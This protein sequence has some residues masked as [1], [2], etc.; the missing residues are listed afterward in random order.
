[1]NLV[2]LKV[3]RISYSQSQNGAYALILEEDDTEDGEFGSLVTVFEDP[4]TF[5][6]IITLNAPPNLTNFFNSP[7]IVNVDRAATVLCTR[8]ISPE[9]LTGAVVGTDRVRA[10]AG[11][12]DRRGVAAVT[13]V[14]AVA[15][16]AMT[17]LT[18]EV[19][20]TR[21]TVRGRRLQIDL[22]GVGSALSL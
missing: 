14:T 6:N 22:E 13:A 7:V 12:A 10:V 5:E 20:V 2:E 16:L 4:V 19:L 21:L 11:G 9:A 1:M 3:N 17:A 18:I 15:I 8:R